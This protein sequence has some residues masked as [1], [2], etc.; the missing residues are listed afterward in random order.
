[1][2][3]ESEIRARLDWQNSNY[4]PMKG[5]KTVTMIHFGRKLIIPREVHV[6]GF[7]GELG[8]YVLKEVRKT[9]KVLDM[10]TGS[11]INAILS[12]SKSSDVTGVD[13][14]SFAIKCAKKNAKLNNVSSKIRF[15]KSNLF[16]NVKGK[17]DLIIFDPPFR[18]FKP[19][20]I[21]ERATTDHNFKTLTIFFKRVKRYLKK[22][23]RILM[24][25]GTSGDLNYFKQLIK[26][27]RFVVKVLDRREI[28]RYNR[29][30]MYYSYLLTTS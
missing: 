14:N 2:M 20:D 25:Y 11:G 6:P 30:W 19:R 16:Q 10:G 4:K 9:D 8:R 5:R 27:E 1:M 12:A 22:D 3:S 13:T 28:D 15:F 23:G 24:Y 17:F 26:K 29:K 18:W 7:S 21:R